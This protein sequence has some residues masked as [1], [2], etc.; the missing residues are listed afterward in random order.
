MEISD[1]KS[2]I[3]FIEIATKYCQLI[4]NVDNKTQT[5]FLQEVFVLLP[6]LCVCG[7]RLP[8]THEL[9]AYKIPEI[10]NEQ[11]N[12]LSTFGQ[13]LEGRDFYWEI[14]DPYKEN[15]EPMGGLLSDDFLGIYR[16]I[17]PGLQ[18]WEKTN[19]DT[20]RHDI[21]WEWKFSF[22]T[23]WGEHSTSAF[24][25]LYHWLYRS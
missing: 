10:S 16:D 2:V 12:D 1:N 21:I 7:I 11:W 6:Q 3:D 9:S 19:E 15:H 17:K 20:E 24:R 23:H 5:Q 18:N 8:E 22:E 25:V 4:E 13:K 14:S